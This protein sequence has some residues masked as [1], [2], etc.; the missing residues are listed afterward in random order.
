MELKHARCGVFAS[1]V[2]SSTFVNAIEPASV[3]LGPVSMEPTL[4][5]RTGHSDNIFFTAENQKSSAVTVINPVVQ[6]IAEDGANA[7]KLTAD[8]RRGVYHSSK[9]DNYT[10]LQLFGDANIIFDVRKKLDLL[11]AYLKAHEARGTGT[12]TEG[13]NATINDAPIKYNQKI[14][15]A[16]YTY[17]VDEAQGRIV[18]KLSYTVR[19]Y[20]NFRSL[21]EP[22]DYD[23]LSTGVTFYYRVMPKT[24]LLFE[25]RRDD[26]NYQNDV[27]AASSLDSTEWK[28][29]VGAT[30]DATA[31]T[32]GVV[33]AGY[34]KK[35]FSADARDDTG[36]FSWEAEVSWAPR[37]YS[38]FV[39]RTGQE[40]EESNGNDDY[41]DT[42]FMSINWDHSW[43]DQLDTALA[44][45]FT[46]GSYD[47]TNREDD[48]N[49][50]TAGVSYDL[51]RWMTLGLDVYHTE[52]SSNQAEYEYDDNGVYLSLQ[53]SL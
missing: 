47:L 26:I 10:D 9:D 6:F 43:N 21:T 52:R 20:T 50:V 32:T 17:G 15:G 7:Y 16:T 35:N 29:L 27:T 24:S 31:K 13:P 18:G 44:Y 34:T 51:R 28:Y 3:S 39:L 41:I 30:W 42:R 11:A 48:T 5:V 45:A 33:K 25:V 22:R 4:T 46:N 38:T 36:E 37:T 14:V 12:I 49:S 23:I 1:L 2:L 40:L 8:L 53:G 19:D